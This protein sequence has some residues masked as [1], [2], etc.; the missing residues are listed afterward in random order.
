LIGIAAA[1]GISVGAALVL[2]VRRE[3]SVQ[4]PALGLMSLALAIALTLAGAPLPGLAVLLLGVFA[5]LFLVSTLSRPFR[6]GAVPAV[7]PQLQHWVSTAVAAVVA[8]AT[9]AVLIGI[10]IAGRSALAG[11]E[12]QSPSITEVCHRLLVG[13]GVGALGLL[14]LVAI[15]LV[16][17]AT[18]V[19]RDRREL[20][21]EQSEANRRRRA[22][23][24]QRRAQQRAEARAAARAARRGARP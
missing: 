5:D 9:L 14:L 6:E 4:L 20:A 7:A 2:L 22:L 17:M 8:A 1:G 24:Q 16:G 21:E 3:R 10:G 13:S 23:E 11:R 15:V 12:K 19:G 18:L